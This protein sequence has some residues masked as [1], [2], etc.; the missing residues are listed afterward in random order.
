MTKV[1]QNTNQNPVL[2]LHPE[3]W[4]IEDEIEISKALGGK[5]QTPIS[6][7]HR[8]LIPGFRS[9]TSLKGLKECIDD[10]PHHDFLAYKKPIIDLN[11][12]KHREK[13]GFEV[14]KIFNGYHQKGIPIIYSANTR[15]ENKAQFI[16][17]GGDDEHFIE[18]LS[19]G[20]GLRGDAEI[21]INRI[22]EDME[23]RAKDEAIATF[24]HL[25][26]ANG[27]HKELEQKIFGAYVSGIN[28]EQITAYR[29]VRGYLFDFWTHL[30]NVGTHFLSIRNNNWDFEI[31]N[32]L[33]YDSGDFIAQICTTDAVIGIV[34]Q[35]QS[36]RVYICIPDIETLENAKAIVYD[37]IGDEDNFSNRLIDY[38]MAQRMLALYI[39]GSRI[40]QKKIM[41][42]APV[43]KYEE[44]Q[45]AFDCGLWEAKA[46]N[47]IDHLPE[48]AA[49]PTFQINDLFYCEVEELEE[50]EALIRLDTVEPKGESVPVFRNFNLQALQNCGIYNRNAQFK[51]ALYNTGNGGG[52]LLLPIPPNLH[53]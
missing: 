51:L 11:L 3:F 46:T 48:K 40:E 13:D 35:L 50:T 10:L 49:H 47:V 1:A 33:S 45:I 23:K 53:H 6:T 22:K 52:Y 16:K 25:L 30:L 37:Y 36:K 5:L 32:T 12:G 38:L 17:L 39:K 20:R 26:V 29:P 34:F 9:F 44:S 18:K 15:D 7:R 21:L 14:V 41:E 27:K 31:Q 43:L 42:F 28:L 4:H 2:T 19:S 8:L 24:P